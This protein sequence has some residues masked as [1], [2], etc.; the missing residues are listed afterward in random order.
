MGIMLFVSSKSS[1]AHIVIF[2][3]KKVAVTH[4]IQNYFFHKKNWKKKRQ[5]VTSAH[6]NLL[7]KKLRPQH[8]L[9]SIYK[10]CVL[11]TYYIVLRTKKWLIHGTKK[12][13]IARQI[14]Y[15]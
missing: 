9:Y 12:K 11:N 3:E 7:F 15:T 6:I 1:S 14:W 8:I 10:N 13:I 5:K 2:L 4:I